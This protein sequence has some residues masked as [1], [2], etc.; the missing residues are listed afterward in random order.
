M[1]TM[2]HS[3]KEMHTVG[4]NPYSQSQ[5]ASLPAP[6]AFQSS[7][8]AAVLLG[9]RMEDLK[10]ATANGTFLHAVRV[11][12]NQIGVMCDW[13][14]ENSRFVRKQTYLNV[15]IVTLIL[16]VCF[17]FQPFNKPRN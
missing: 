15:L 4:Y 3:F 1:Q 9:S 2:L 17:V 10:R 5:G 13:A 6:T 7:S 11:S 14:F 12:P 8:E 16:Y